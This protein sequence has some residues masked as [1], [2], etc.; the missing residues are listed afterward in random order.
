[1][2]NHVCTCVFFL[3]KHNIAITFEFLLYIS[4][5]VPHLHDPHMCASI[6]GSSLVHCFE[7]HFLV[8]LLL[9]CI[10]FHCMNMKP[11]FI[12]LKNTLGL[13]DTWGFP[14]WGCYK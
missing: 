6:P 1:M 10:D 9:L 14:I 2:T 4:S 5:I 3:K 13:M 12:P 11:I 8:A 7:I